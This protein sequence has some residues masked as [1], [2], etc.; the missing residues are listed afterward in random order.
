MKLPSWVY[1]LRNRWR[2]RR[3]ALRLKG[4]RGF[5]KRRSKRSS[6]VA[7]DRLLLEM[8]EWYEPR[9]NPTGELSLDGPSLLAELED[10]RD[11]VM[12]EDASTS[13]YFW[14]DDQQDRIE[15]FVEAGL[16]MGLGYTEHNQAHTAYKLSHAGRTRLYELRASDG[17]DRTLRIAVAALLLTLLVDL[18]ALAF[19]IFS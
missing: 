12:P 14:L 6:R 18:V 11:H 15:E 4:A 17:R 2:R 16:V 7:D 13:G 1:G 8:I 9:R 3:F 5:L 19:V 10:Y